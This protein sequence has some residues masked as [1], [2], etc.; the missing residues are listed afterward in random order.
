MKFV[1]LTEN[2]LFSKTY[3]SRQRALTRTV[4]VYVLKDR[5]EKRLRAANPLKESINRLG[6]SASKKIGGAV[7]R[8]R[9]K[10]VIREAFRQ[11]DREYDVKKGWLVVI[12]ARY[13]ATVLKTQDVFS[14]LLYCL[15]KA[16]MLNER[17]GQPE[18][19]E[20]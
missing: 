19:D 20:E 14:D 17:S 9:A 8:N 1:S 11:I 10:R 12:V 3:A 13:H 16:E 2:H 5:H 6:V 7:E 18:K 15:R 4:A